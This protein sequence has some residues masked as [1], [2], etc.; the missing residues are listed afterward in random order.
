MVG[1]AVDLAQ[2]TTIADALAPIGAVDHLVVTAIDQTPNR[3]AEF[4]VEQAVRMATI[5]L[6]GYTE[7]VRVLRPRMGDQASVVLFGGLARDRP[8]PGSTMV[9]AVNGGVTALVRTLAVELAPLRVNAV[10]PGVVGDS[11]K[12]RDVVDHPH[13]ARTPVGRLVTMGEVAEAVDLLLANGGGQRPEPRRRRGRARHLT[14][15]AATGAAG[16]RGG[17]VQ[18]APPGPAGR[19]ARP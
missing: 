10:H 11:P 4:D 8:Y 14:G 3:V 19:L 13:V 7:V 5:K 12:W 16:R 17:S 6:V 9:T 1:L 2:P 15:A 18:Y